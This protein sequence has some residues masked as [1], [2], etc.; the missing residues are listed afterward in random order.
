MP[1]LAGQIVGLVGRVAVQAGE[2]GDEVQRGQV[3]VEAVVFR[4][5]AQRRQQA[6]V[7]PGGL[8]VDLHLALGGAQLA[9]EQFYQGGLARAV[10]AQQADYVCLA[11]E[12][13]IVD[14]DHLAEPLG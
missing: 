6:P 10:G 14:R 8:P 12:G 4:A 13:E 9:A 11:L 2:Q 1:C 3:L 7:V 5:V